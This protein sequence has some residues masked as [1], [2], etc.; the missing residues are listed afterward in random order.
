MSL[1]FSVK[2]KNQFEGLASRPAFK[3]RVR[4]TID[5]ISIPLLLTELNHIKKCCFLVN[6]NWNGYYIWIW[7]SMR[8]TLNKNQKFF[9][10]FQKMFDLVD[11]KLRQLRKWS[12][13]KTDANLLKFTS[14]ISQFS[15]V[16]AHSSIGLYEAKYFII[17]SKTVS[18]SKK[19]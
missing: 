3:I 6:L 5:P 14:R 2:I 7:K 12:R 17:L 18:A 15:S 13:M 1:N 11:R 9:Q 10:K 16:S 19:K 8:I 4:A